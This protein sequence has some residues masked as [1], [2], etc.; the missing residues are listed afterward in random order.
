MAINPAQGTS[1]TLYLLV[2][3]SMD[4][5]REEIAIDVIK[6]LKEQNLAFP[7][8]DNFLIFDNSSKYS[9]HLSGVP[10]GIKIAHSN[11]NIGY[12]SA[13]NW[14]INNHQNIFKRS[15]DYIYIIESDLYH[16][17][18]MALK[19]CE[20]FLNKH[21][22]IGS[23]RTQEFSVRLKFLYDK[24]YAWL[25]LPKNNSVVSQRNAITNE[26]VWFK[27]SS[28]SSRIWITNFHTKL[29]ALN[30]MS[31][32]TDVFKRLTKESLIVSE[33]QFMHFYYDLYKLTGLLDGGAFRIM[34]SIDSPGLSGSYSS[35][36]ALNESGYRGTR[37][38]EIIV[39]G[40]EINF[41]EK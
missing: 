12:W 26:R 38:D 11:K 34:N 9:S 15:Y 1:S 6:N 32:M 21:P 10:A 41:L 4:I 2:T 17:D 5:N 13:I 18:L 28:P 29:P 31:A 35:V 23:I 24:K 37:I 14:V 39:D 8:F 27:K 30:R 20:L 3:C 16:Y 22:E 36:S 7:F 40:F 25:P 19:E 33:I